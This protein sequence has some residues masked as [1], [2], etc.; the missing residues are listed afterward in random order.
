LMWM[1]TRSH[2]RPVV[3]GEEH[4]IGSRARVV[5][6]QGQEG[7][8]HVHGELWHARGPTGLIAGQ[9]VWVKAIGGLTV[10]VTPDR[11]VTA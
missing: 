11:E 5:D 6:W 10:E 8:V 2:R 1:L 3:T 4:M 7:R 9:E